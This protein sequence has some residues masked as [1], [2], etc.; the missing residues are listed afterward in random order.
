V[1]TAFSKFQEPGGNMLEN[2]LV[3]F[4]NV[5][6]GKHHY[7]HYTYS[8]TTVG[9]LGGAL[10]TGRYLHYPDKRHCI[11]DLFVSWANGFGVPITTFGV[12]KY[13]KGPLPGYLG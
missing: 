10:R 4:I 2:S 11:S 7:G 6:G 5:G 3:A 1:A 12:A 13:C 9:R 8:A